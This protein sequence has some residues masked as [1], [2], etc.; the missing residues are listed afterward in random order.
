MSKLKVERKE[1]KCLLHVLKEERTPNHKLLVS[2]TKE[3]RKKP[4]QNGGSSGSEQQRSEINLVAKSLG[5]VLSLE[6]STTSEILY[7]AEDAHTW[8]LDSDATFHVTPH[9]EWFTDYSQSVG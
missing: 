6:G 4:N 9:H 1:S 5:E 3:Q 2:S 8:L 7:S